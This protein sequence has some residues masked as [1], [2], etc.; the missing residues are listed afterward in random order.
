MAE[1]KGMSKGCM[2]ALIVAGVIL[3]LVI[4]GAITCYVYWD[5]AVKTSM[6]AVVD[7]AKSTVA[8]YPPNG[9]DTTSFNALAD[10]FVERFEPGELDAQEYGPLMTQLTQALDDD[11]LTPEEIESLREEM[12]RLY[13]ELD[14]FQPVTTETDTMEDTTGAMP[15]TGSTM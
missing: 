15:D 13:P 14:R 1:G 8:E 3:V 12:I 2:V 6:S 7:K 5:D 10:T 4:I 9:V 11:R